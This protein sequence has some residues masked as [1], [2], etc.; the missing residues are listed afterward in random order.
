MKWKT[1]VQFVT[2]TLL[3]DI[4]LSVSSV[5]FT[6]NLNIYVQMCNLDNW[7]ISI[8]FLLTNAC[9]WRNPLGI[10]AKRPLEEI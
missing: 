8:L 4:K 9:Y 1:L 7:Y 3:H 5:F 6:S 2:R 10:W